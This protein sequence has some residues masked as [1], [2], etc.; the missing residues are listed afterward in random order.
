MF[1]ENNMADVSSVSAHR[2]GILHYQL[3]IQDNCN[4]ININ[5]NRTSERPLLDLMDVSHDGIQR[6][7]LQDPSFV[8]S[9]RSYAIHP[10]MMLT[11]STDTFASTIVDGGDEPQIPHLAD[12]T[13]VLVNSDAFLHEDGLSD[14]TCDTTY[15]MDADAWGHGLDDT[16]EHD[17]THG[18]CDPV[19]DPMHLNCRLRH[20]PLE[21]GQ[22]T[23]V[24]AST[25]DNPI[26]RNT[27]L[28]S[29][30]GG[31]PWQRYRDLHHSRSNIF[32]PPWRS[33]ASASASQNDVS[34]Q[35][36]TQTRNTQQSHESTQS[37]SDLRS[38]NERTSGRSSSVLRTLVRPGSRRLSSTDSVQSLQLSTPNSAS[39]TN[40]LVTDSTTQA[41]S[42]PIVN[43][44]AR[45]PI[46]LPTSTVSESS[47]PS[48]AT[49]SGTIVTTNNIPSLTT[50]NQ[51]PYAIST[52]NSS[53]LS[54]SDIQTN[55]LSSRNTPEVTSVSSVA[56]PSATTTS[57]QPIATQGLGFTNAII[58]EVADDS[59]DRSEPSG[60]KGKSKK[61]RNKGKSLTSKTATDKRPVARVFP[62]FR[63]VPTTSSSTAASSQQPQTQTN[64]ISSTTTNINSTPSLHIS[65]TVSIGSTFSAFTPRSFPY[66]RNQYSNNRP[67]S[68]IPSTQSI[69]PL[70]TS[71]ALNTRSLTPAANT[72]IDLATRPVFDGY[73]RESLL[74]QD[75]NTSIGTVSS[76]TLDLIRAVNR[77]LP[78]SRDDTQL[79]SGSDFVFVDEDVSGMYAAFVNR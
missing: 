10:E 38:K 62:R 61:N 71:S 57:S 20:I 43:P 25:S 54:T 40:A 78:R 70:P 27:P 34:S 19:A 69:S 72:T 1:E 32:V 2:N 26:S 59:C 12:N 35:P 23:H 75:D 14:I 65:S 30:R 16:I 24:V 56:M 4:G 33:G 22:S 7:Q 47:M 51:N 52:T 67:A 74:S 46:S 55:V 17:T 28:R 42:V 60:G 66:N 31:Y 9:E 21:G 37:V 58:E 36:T 8:D 45:V 68:A 73:S 11:A 64:P 77:M 49:N 15:L 13:T 41:S 18:M 39:V 63:T 79:E 6:L 53:S 5:V 3:T 44:S 50:G 48:I 29:S 76:S